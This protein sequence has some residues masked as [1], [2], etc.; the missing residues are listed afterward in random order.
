MSFLFDLMKIKLML[1]C[2]LGFIVYSFIWI[3]F[4]FRCPWLV[5]D[6]TALLISSQTS[7]RWCLQ[8]QKTINVLFEMTFIRTSVATTL[9]VKLFI[10][11][12]ITP[13]SFLIIKALF[14][15]WVRFCFL[16]TIVSVFKHKLRDILKTNLS[17]K[18]WT[19]FLT[20]GDMGVGVF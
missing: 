19:I 10:T 3:P 16:Y 6:V 15:F 7:V 12:N 5:L 18:V 1:W 2:L 9:L 20:H 13:P 14:P 8:P 17:W 4:I 11:V